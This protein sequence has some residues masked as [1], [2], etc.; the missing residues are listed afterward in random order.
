MLKDV[1]LY[2]KIEKDK[3]KEIIKYLGLKIA[4]LQR[5]VK[6]YKIPVIIVF[7]GWD[8]S[9]KG[10]LINNLILPMDPR[11][12]N[13]YTMHKPNE[14]EKMRP[15]L[16]RFWTKT[17]ERGRI[18]IFDRSW[19]RK[20]FEDR[21]D[22]IIKKKE[23]EK[24]YEQINSF[25]RQLFDDG[26]IIIKFF[27]HISEKQ[28]SKRMRR[29]EESKATSWRVTEKDWKHNRQY[30]EY[31]KVIDE[32]IKVTNFE[33]GPWVIVEGSDKKFATVKIFNTLIKMLEDRIDSIN[34]KQKAKEIQHSKIVTLDKEKSHISKIES[35]IYNNEYEMKKY[36]LDDIDL[37]KKLHK[38]EYKEQLKK[39]QNK[40]KE[41]QNE[42]YLRK[43]P[44]VIVYE[45]WDASGKGGNIK[46]VTKNMDPRGYEVISV[47]APNDMELNH[48]YLWR[49]WC[50]IPKAGHIA[51]FDRSWYGRVLV[52]RIE[53][54]CTEKEWKRAYRELN[55]MERNI[56]GFGGAVLK[57]WLHI[58]KEEQLKRFNER[59]KNPY[60][61][62]KITDEDWR[63]RD[64]WDSYKS[65]VDDM[66]LK[67]NTEYAP[68]IIVE[69]N[70]KYF[71]RVKVLENIVKKVEK[72]F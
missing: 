47:A 24:Y 36:V 46:R 45:G 51:I 6:E 9:G 54:F 2:K 19:Y 55:E 39:Y 21:V 69:A 8:A 64:K 28:Q 30:K 72:K 42:I 10:I 48:H 11:Y 37:S 67:T 3:Y 34:K 70:D 20:T 16:W 59:K 63:N 68:W 15:F 35:M 1:D 71:A 50:K 23:I 49:F 12:F 62:W 66:I 43:I 26:N 22:G 60:K 58:D 38:E 56:T 61:S 53:G 32:T 27:I 52:E 17:P 41:L 13:V 18:A 65:A 14:E 7:E 33:Y 44:V 57:F 31:L 4:E 29:L 5:K 25:E 40:I